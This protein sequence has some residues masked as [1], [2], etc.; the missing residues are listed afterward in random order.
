MSFTGK[1]ELS[2]LDPVENDGFWPELKMVDLATQ[3]RVP[4]EL[5]NDIIK[6]RLILAIIDINDKLTPI[7]TS[8]VAADYEDFAAYNTANE[9]KIGDVDVLIKKYEEAVFSY[10]KALILQLVKTL[11]RKAE[12]ENLAKESTETESYWLNKSAAAV[13][14]LFSKILPTE[15][16]KTGFNARLIT[17]L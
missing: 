1:P 11:I 15:S 14:F 2:D 5:D 16:S 9:L 13:N 3:Y 4:S 17:P 10:A 7:K 8:I 6:D 12:A